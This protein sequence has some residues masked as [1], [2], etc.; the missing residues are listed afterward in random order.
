MH[1]ALDA[2]SD[3]MK[4]DAGEL[5]ALLAELL[6]GDLDELQQ[7][8]LARCIATDPLAMQAYLEHCELHAFLQ[9]ENGL[10]GGMDAVDLDAPPRA[11]QTTHFFARRWVGAAAALLAF[12]ATLAFFGLNR[13]PA[14]VAADES[15]FAA[16]LS[17]VEDAR[18]DREALVPGQA[19]HDGQRLELAQ[20][21]AELTFAS[22]A[23]VMLEGPS[24]L[25][26]SS[27]WD[28][29]LLDGQAHV[30]IPAQARG[31][32]LISSDVEI[33]RGSEFSVVSHEPGVSELFVHEGTLEGSFRDEAGQKRTPLTLRAKESRKFSNLGATDIPDREKRWVKLQRRLLAT[34]PQLETTRLQW[35][36]DGDE[37]LALAAELN[38][39]PESQRIVRTPRGHPASP[40][41]ISDGRIN[42]ALHISAE[43]ALA[44][45]LPELSKATPRSLTFWIRLEPQDAADRTL[46]EC[47]VPGG[48]K[49]LRPLRI[50][51][52][53][54]Q[55]R[56]AR[57]TLQTDQGRLSMISAARIDDGKWHH[58]AWVFVVG[59]SGPA[60][61]YVDGRLD[62]ATSKSAQ[63]RPRR[64]VRQERD[65]LKD[66]ML[67]LG[68]ALSLDVDELTLVDRALTPHEIGLMAAPPKASA[69]TPK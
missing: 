58:V 17:A 57:G 12:C 46:A 1:Q 51:L 29:T 60:L 59:E 48:K 5:N 14:N 26:V 13:A 4:E 56:G 15:A 50:A 45:P 66:G 10:L 6:D 3:R 52:N 42:S 39:A 18:W 64:L 21:L 9:W 69:G 19:L 27:A 62:G 23:K 28:A 8:R 16:V 65:E 47:L 7:Q 2:G 34:T 54:G 44:F 41:I 40:A 31:F 33:D 24:S 49:G 36:F 61:Q 43:G 68:G 37:S 11:A 63:A 30:A 32:R 67:L 55:E 20:G 53:D 35:H 38:G 25:D 22:G